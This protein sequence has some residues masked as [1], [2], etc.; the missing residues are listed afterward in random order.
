MYLPKQLAGDK[1]I[2][3]GVAVPPV[4][5]ELATR[6][7]E[8]VLTEIKHCEDDWR[9]IYEDEIAYIE[10]I[11]LEDFNDILFRHGLDENLEWIK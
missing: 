2:F 7:I 3:K 8:L 4:V 6:Y 10:Q 11:T 9:K 1:L 5:E